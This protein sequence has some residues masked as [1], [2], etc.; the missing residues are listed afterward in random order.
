M[1]SGPISQEAL[2]S[3]GRVIRREIEGA[4]FSQVAIETRAELSR[5]PSPRLP[6]GA[7]RPMMETEPAAI[8]TESLATGAAFGLA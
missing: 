1:G 7:A 4:G 6:A 8:L 2:R 3:N 5:A